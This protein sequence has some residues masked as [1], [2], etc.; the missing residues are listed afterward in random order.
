MEQLYF[1]LPQ[2]SAYRKRIEIFTL[3]IRFVVVLFL[4][5]LLHKNFK[6]TRSRYLGHLASSASVNKILAYSKNYDKI[7]NHYIFLKLLG[8]PIK[9]S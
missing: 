3:Q 1:D 4:S 7:K 8:S 9:F 2:I 5:L 6:N